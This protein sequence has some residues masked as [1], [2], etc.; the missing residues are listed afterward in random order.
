MVYQVEEGEVKKHLL[1]RSVLLVLPC[2]AAA[3]SWT[4]GSLQADELGT[5]GKLSTA[6]HLVAITQGGM[7]YDK[8]WG[9]LGKAA[10]K[11]THPAY[12]KAGKKKGATTWRCKE[13]HGWDYKGAA[14]AYA[15]GSHYTGITGIRNMTHAPLDTIVAILKDDTH[16]YG[17]LMSDKELTT[18]A[19]FV[20]HGQIDTDE[21]I[22]RAT[23]KVK[24]DAAKGERIFQTTCARCHGSD[25]KLINFK[26]PPKAEYVG[27]VA[28]ANPWEALHKVRMGQPGVFMISMLAFDIQDHLDVLAYMQTLPKK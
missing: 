18:L 24:G 6:E 16:G 9:Q 14:G 22:D 26:A 10:P 23:K 20:A 27:T 25:G 7:M 8:W 1:K 15:K 4:P 11:G 2:V 13:C 28:N 3:L 5:F 12:P 19:H 21:Y 17:K